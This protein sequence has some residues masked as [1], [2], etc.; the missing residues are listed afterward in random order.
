MTEHTSDRFR[1]ADALF[2]AVLDVPT[3]EQDDYLV[4]AAGD[5]TAL[6]EDVR[7]LLAAHRA[8][9]D[10]LENA[11]RPD[12]AAFLRD[13]WDAAV[14]PTLSRVGPFRV[15]REI[16]RGGMG[17]VYLAERDDAQFEQRVALKVV[18]GLGAD[19]SLVRRFREERRILARLEHRHI[20]RLLDGGVTDDGTPWFAME[21]IEGERMDRWC[22]ARSLS[23]DAR[24]CLFEAAC[25][26]VQYAHRQL[27]VHRDLKPSNIMVTAAGELKLLDFGVARLLSAEDSEVTQ[28]VFGMTPQ[29]AAPEQVRGQP[30]TTA[31]DIYAL[32]V[33]LYEL[34]TGKRPYDVSQRSPAEIER[35]VCDVEPPRPSSTFEGDDAADR[36]RLRATTPDRLQRRL[37]GDLDVIV[38]KAMKKNPAERYP[39]AA[40]LAEDLRR[41]LR[42]Q[43]ISAR[44]DSAAYKAAKFVRRHRGGVAVATALALGTVLVMLREYRLRSLAEAET[45]T[46]RSVEQYLL[47]VFGSADPF[48]P[49]DS[50]AARATAREL[51]DRGTARLDTALATEPQVRSRIRTALGRVY[52]NLGLYDQ[53]SRQL[54]LALSE[55]R[56]VN[57]D[58][59]TAAAAT[60]DELGLLR[61]RQGRIDEA[62]SLL[63][64]ALDRHRNVSGG[65]DSAT[66]AT[67][68]HLSEVRRERNEFPSAEAL[69]REALS[70]R[71][72]LQGDSALA[73]SIS[74]QMLAEVLHDQGADSAAAPLYRE[75]LGIRERVVG[76][77]HPLVA[78][79]M[80]NLALTERRLGH[81]A[82]SESLYRQTLDIQRQT[83]GEDHPSVAS[84]LNGLADLL[85]KA[86]SRSDEA[87]ALLRQALTI[88]RRR[89]GEQHV[90]V[91]T[92]LGNLAAIVR[93]RGDYA[94]A[95]KLLRQA[96]AIDEATFGPEHSYVGYDLNELATIL[97]MRGKPDSATPIF[98][99]VLA[100]NR[101]IAG[102]GHRNTLAVKVQLGRALREDGKF[103]DAADVFREA[104]T[105]LKPDNPDTDPFTVGATIGLGRS[106]VR[107]GKEDE[108]LPLLRNALA[109]STAKFGATNYRTA[110]AHLGLG[111][112][113]IALRRM[114]EARSALDSARAIVE[115]QKRAQPVLSTEIER[116]LRR[117]PQA[118]NGR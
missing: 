99:R 86:A 4:A 34:L 49:Q 92:N 19:A 58:R 85:H 47:T 105:H 79:T 111:E 2:D 1:R 18:R 101:K 27:V 11:A 41:H 116:E 6:L 38:A 64:M 91:S 35:I 33:L 37:R 93:E 7:Q 67:L 22:D 82:A 118:P 48:L 97:R 50:S 52:A 74:Q 103:A 109:S 59:N 95:E 110:E 20:A 9:G 43:T 42:D 39:T 62:D 16:G 54:E 88:N 57:G 24:L 26:A 83:L 78:K 29:Y 30:I 51:L 8:S 72:A 32:G 94:E 104:L 115:P 60:L 56:A 102:E 81:I 106:L 14:T 21:F 107:L 55:Q 87:E 15:V 80:F 63:S 117:L 76:R 10:F 61:D 84:T 17:A 90:E 75:A 96:L 112:C 5:D 45:R 13:S 31:T 71:R 100:M 65:R 3:A 66:A 77:N 108:A 73:T 46:A 89:L 69:I 53:S 23:V 28:T 40:A 12:G 114:G 36:A 25:E 44:P 70:I 98:R 68:E 113:F